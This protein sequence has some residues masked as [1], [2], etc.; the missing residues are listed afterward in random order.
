MLRPATNIPA[1]R[2]FLQFEMKLVHFTINQSITIETKGRCIL[3]IIGNKK[4]SKE[5]KQSF[6]LL[7]WEGIMDMNSLVLN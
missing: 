5:K 4:K 3:R 2:N 1:D 7:L 6:S